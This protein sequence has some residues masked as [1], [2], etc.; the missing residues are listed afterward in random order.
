MIAGYKNAGI[1]LEG[2]WLDIPYMSNDEDFK[3]ALKRADEHLYA[4]KASGRNTFITDKGF[5]PSIV[6]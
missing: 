3:A 4:A 2:V 1:P 6:S 5:V